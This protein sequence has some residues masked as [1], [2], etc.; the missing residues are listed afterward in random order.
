MAGRR[1]VDADCSDLAAFAAVRGRLGA[2]DT[3]LCLPHV[4]P[5]RLV[6]LAKEREILETQI[7]QLY[8]EW[9]A[10]EAVLQ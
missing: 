3:E 8:A 5:R 6:V 10:A 7:A 1:D 2:V 9:E 4:D